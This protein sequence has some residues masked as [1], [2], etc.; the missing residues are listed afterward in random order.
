M[1]LKQV[2]YN[3]FSNK[4]LRTFSAQ[5]MDYSIVGH[6]ESDQALTQLPYVPASMKEK[7][8]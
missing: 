6:Q 8:N 4:E 3:K 1:Y 7:I 5:A 2:L